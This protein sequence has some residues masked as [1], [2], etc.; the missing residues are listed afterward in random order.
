MGVTYDE[1]DTYLLGGEISEESKAVIDRLHKVSE[2]K[3]CA[4]PMPEKIKREA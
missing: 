1:I 4:A 3:R 2:H